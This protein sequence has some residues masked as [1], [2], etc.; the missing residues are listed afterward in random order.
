MVATSDPLDI[1]AL[2]DLRMQLGAEVQPVLVPSQR[3][4]EVIND[5]YGRKQDKGGDLGEKDDEE[6]EGASEELVDILE[7]TDEAPIIRWV[8]SLLFNAVKERASDIHI[9][10]GEKEV[11]VRYRIDGVLYES[12][13][14][15]A[16]VHALDHLAREDH[17]RAEH[18]REAAAAGRPHPPQ[19]RR[20]GHRHARRH[21]PHASRR[22]SASPSVCS[23][24]SRCCTTWPTSASATI[25]CARWTS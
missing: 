12:R 13:Q 22:A 2:D 20:Q 4:L 16:P 3:I 15:R 9:E 1:G 21:R 18:R 10:P 19:D 8:N 25:T 7:L 14:A 17:G 5:V 11:Q 6:D 23:T 24:A